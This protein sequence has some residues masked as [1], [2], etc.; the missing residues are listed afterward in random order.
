MLP[1]PAKFGEGVSQLGVRN[2]D[3]VVVYDGRYVAFLLVVDGVHAFSVC[4]A[5]GKGVFSAPRLA[6]MF[7]VFGHSNVAVLGPCPVLFPLSPMWIYA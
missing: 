1:S 6:W 3:A 7:N 2:D 5:P 4:F